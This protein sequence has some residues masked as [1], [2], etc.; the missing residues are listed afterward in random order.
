M[1]ALSPYIVSRTMMTEEEARKRV[2]AINAGMN[3]IRMLLLDFHDREGWKALGYASWREC[4]TAEF[5]QSK[6]HLYRQLEAARIEERI[7]QASVDAG[8]KSFSPIG[9]KSEG[10]EEEVPFPE[11]PESHLR[12]L[13]AVP[14]EDQ[15]TV[16]RLAKETAPNGIMTAAHVGKTVRELGEEKPRKAGKKNQGGDGWAPPSSA[17]SLAKRVSFIIAAIDTINDSEPKAREA[18]AEIAVHV[19]NRQHHR[20]SV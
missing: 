9:E 19:W 14:P 17:W 10:P 16:Y 13:A 11:I 1:E 20:G 15:P 5:G 8:E 2:V 7:L 4:V 3:N 6:T 12:P 18:L